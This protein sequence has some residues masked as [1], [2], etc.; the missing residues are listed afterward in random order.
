[1]LILTALLSTQCNKLVLTAARGKRTYCRSHS[2][3]WVSVWSRCLTQSWMEEAGAGWA[4]RCTPP[5]FSGVREQ[6]PGW[7]WWTPGALGWWSLRTS[8]CPSCS[9]SRWECWECRRWGARGPEGGCQSRCS[10]WAWSRSTA[11]GGRS[12]ARRSRRGACRRRL[13]LTC[14]GTLSCGWWW[15]G[16]PEWR[17]WTRRPRCQSPPPGRCSRGWRRTDS[18]PPPG[19]HTS[20]RGNPESSC[21]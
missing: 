16:G 17:C 2:P 5:R 20:A 12:E 1:M 13:S 14:C 10:C 15:R 21:T 9:A 4:P 8:S 6:N 11:S 19:D 7:K 3:S 18:A